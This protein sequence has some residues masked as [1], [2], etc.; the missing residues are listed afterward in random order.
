MEIFGG[1]ATIFGMASFFLAAIWFITPFVIFAIKG[2]V[3][4]SYQLLEQ[5]EQRIAAIERRLPPTSDGDVTVQPII[6]APT[7]S[8]SLQTGHSSDLP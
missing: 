4:R 5:L 7:A 2:K 1:L 3:D 6:P 8:D